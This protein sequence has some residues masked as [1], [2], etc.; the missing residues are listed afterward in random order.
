MYDLQSSSYA[1]QI[2]LITGAGHGLGKELSLRF[3]KLGGILVLWDIDKDKCDKTAKDI[4]NLGGRAY[5][6]HV[7][8]S[9]VSRVMTTAEKVKEEIG[10]PDIVINNAAIVKVQSLLDLSPNQIRKTINVNLLSHFW[11]IKSF[12]PDMVHNNCG[13]IV[14]ISSNL[15]MA[16]KS[17]FVDYCASKFGVNGLMAALEAE[18]HQ[19]KK[20]NIVLTTVC[21]AAI[22]TGM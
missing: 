19:M 8:V 5:S 6:Y 20:S 18:L 10:L 13:H 21:P 7:D 11:T 17:H 12:L 16:G 1:Y 2:I 15:G 9:E 22:N 14:A 3:S 4:K